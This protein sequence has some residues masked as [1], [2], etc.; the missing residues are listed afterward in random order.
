MKNTAR[1]L[2]AAATTATLALGLSTGLAGAANAAITTP[3][4]A[5]SVS[6]AERGATYEFRFNL[7]V[8]NAPVTF[9]VDGT[10]VGTGTTNSNGDVSFFY[11]PSNAEPGYHKLYAR[12][13][14]GIWSSSGFGTTL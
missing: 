14:Y 3:D 2:A 5:A 6:A 11:A 9:D 1:R 13:L 8:P 12:T 4:S 7:L 10:V